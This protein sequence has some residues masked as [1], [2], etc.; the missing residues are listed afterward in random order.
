MD[1][2]RDIRDD[3]AAGRLGAWAGDELLGRID[4]FVLDDDGTGAGSAL[5]AVHTVVEPDHQGEGVAGALA[6][7]L[8]DLAASESRS[9][10]PLCPY[11]AAWSVKHSDRAPQPDPAL[12]DRAK[13]RL[14]ADPDMW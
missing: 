11:V 13:E 7:A 12:T 3:R 5:V 4:Y 6:G 1:N 10:V 14:S 8:Y 9:V 2:G